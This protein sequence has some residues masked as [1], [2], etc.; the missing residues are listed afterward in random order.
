M[1]PVGPIWWYQGDHRSGTGFQR[2]GQLHP[3]GI[4][5]AAIALY[6]FE[7]VIALRAVEDPGMG[8]SADAIYGFRGLR[9][10]PTLA[11]NRI[12]DIGRDMDRPNLDVAIPPGGE[13][14]C[15]AYS[16]YSSR[17]N[18]SRA[19]RASTIAPAHMAHGSSV[20]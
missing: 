5:K 11:P 2:L 18:T 4:G 15:V 3:E 6:G 16:T 12:N 17:P 13:G 10:A 14:E 19:I 8:T 1:N 9:N 20:T 7:A